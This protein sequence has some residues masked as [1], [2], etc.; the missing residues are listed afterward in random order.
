MSDSM[1]FFPELC[2]KSPEQIPDRL[3]YLLA[4]TN[5]FVELQQRALAVAKWF[6]LQ[7][8]QTMARWRRLIEKVGGNEDIADDGP[9][10]G[11]YGAKGQLMKRKA[12]AWLSALKRD[13]LQKMGKN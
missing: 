11:L 9:L 5:R 1:R 12:R 10:F 7:N 2:L 8:G 4:D 6:E 13:M 3:T